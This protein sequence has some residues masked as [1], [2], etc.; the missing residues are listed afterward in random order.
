MRRAWGCQGDQCKNLLPLPR[1][2]FSIQI[3]RL[4][5]QGDRSWLYYC[6][7]ARAALRGH[8]G[9]QCLDTVKEQTLFLSQVRP[10][11]WLPAFTYLYFSPS[12]P[13]DRCHWLQR[14]EKSV[15]QSLKPHRSYQ[16]ESQCPKT[17]A[18]CQVRFQGATSHR[19]MAGCQG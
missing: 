2:D 11:N 5:S 19:G 3:S 6:S 14:T 16:A 8:R 15:E 18:F 7:W 12:Q 17:L 4:G 10:R 9:C 1:P 13:R